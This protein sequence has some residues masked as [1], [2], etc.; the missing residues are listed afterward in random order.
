MGRRISNAFAWYRSNGPAWLTDDHVDRIRTGMYAYELLEKL[1]SGWQVWRKHGSVRR[2]ERWPRLRS[3]WRYTDDVLLTQQ[4]IKSSRL[5]MIL[6]Q[7][8]GLYSGSFHDGVCIS[9]CCL[10][11]VRRLFKRVVRRSNRN[12]GYLKLRYSQSHLYL[13]LRFEAGWFVAEFY[14]QLHMVGEI[15]P[16]TRCCISTKLLNSFDFTI[17]YSG[18]KQ[19]LPP[20]YLLK[21]ARKGPSSLKT[22]CYHFEQNDNSVE[23]KVSRSV[24]V[25]RQRWNIMFDYE[26][27]RLIW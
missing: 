11:S 19:C 5:R 12:H 8:F 27:L 1:R 24:E 10:Y 13:G 25:I 23:D 17:R 18:T 21:F 2:S 4:K 6:S 22:G 26:S 16:P 14:R 7:Q 20:V 3:A 9:S 15:L